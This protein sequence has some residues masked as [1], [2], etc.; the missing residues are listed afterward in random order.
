MTE[1]IRKL[2]LG[3]ELL[4]ST[5]GKL[6]GLLQRRHVRLSGTHAVVLDEADVLMEDATFPLTEIGNAT[7]PSTQFVFATATLPKPTE[8]QIRKEFPS[9]VVYH[10]PGL[11]RVP[12]NTREVLVDCTF[13]KHFPDR[14]IVAS[15]FFANKCDELLSSL[16]ATPAMRTLVFCNSIPQCDDV[17]SFLKKKMQ[18]LE[19]NQV[20]PILYKH[21]G[22]MGVGNRSVALEHLAR[23]GPLITISLREQ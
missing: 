20:V 23:L 4:V 2:R 19:R 12:L 7:L 16:I 6:S 8:L 15:Q 10:G 3:S 22:A 11:H 5:P 18:R 14:R 1:E 21:H 17:E 13:S 9:A